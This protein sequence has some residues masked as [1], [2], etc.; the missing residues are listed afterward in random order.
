MTAAA[1]AAK[2][3]QALS[4]QQG[5]LGGAAVALALVVAGGLVEGLALGRAQGNLLAAR[6][7]G[8]RRGSYVG[9]TL[10]VAGLGWAA[11]SAPGVLSGDDRGTEPPLA[12]MLAGA[13]AIGLVMGPVLG[14][15]QAWVLRGAVPHPWRWVA[16]NTVAWC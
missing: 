15:A 2:G 12:L 9:T 13:A 1:S 8:L 5:L 11:G 14:A 10:V 6:W 16:A 3:V 7:S 4:D